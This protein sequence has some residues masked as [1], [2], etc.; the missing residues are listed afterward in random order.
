MFFSALH[1]QFVGKVSFPITQYCFNRRGIGR[2]FHRSCHSEIMPENLISELQIQHLRITLKHAIRFVP[3]YESLFKR[4]GLQPEDIRSLSDI[5]AI[6]PLSRDN[7]IEA[8][9]SLIDRRYRAS[10]EAANRSTRGPAE[11]MPFA[12]FKKF[13]LVRNTSSGSTGAPTIFYEDGT[14]SAISWANELRI[15]RWYGLHPGIREARLVRVSPDFVMKNKANKIRRLLWNQMILPGVNLTDKEYSLI[16]EQLRQFKPQVIWAFTAAAAGVARYMVE[17]RFISTA[18]SP[19]LVITWAAPLYK[20][21][22]M[23]IEKAFGSSIG[24]IY[25]MREVGHIGAYCP[26][27]SLHVFQESHLVETDSNGELLVTFLRP[28]PMP[29]IRY[30]TGDL[31]E[32]V[33]ERCSCGRTL[34]IIKQFHGR[35]GEIYTTEDGRMFS[36][37]FW[38]RTFMDARLAMEVKRFQ[39]IYAKDRSIKVRMV[40]DEN[41]RSD[42]EIILRQTV[43][44]NFGRNQALSFEYS[45]EIAPQISGKYQMV[46]NENQ[47]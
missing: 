42:A 44:K 25:G 9:L 23:I 18:Y 2:E 32:T 16:I 46:I 13:P 21:E 15:R 12:R 29:F 47:S 35:T 28:S 3:Y 10:V 5:S 14:I 31:G 1:Q 38:C 4:A 39:I 8:R 33:Y 26:A 30:R 6:P 40:L 43:I 37:N 20:H 34:Q 17:Q 19:R 22:R 24:N 36:P 11:P 27:G 7:V 41:K 45:Q